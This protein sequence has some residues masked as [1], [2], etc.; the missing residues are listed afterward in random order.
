MKP[1]QDY[2]FLCS[3]Q[4]SDHANRARSGIAVE[5]SHPWSWWNRLNSPRRVLYIFAY[6]SHFWG[7]KMRLKQ[8]GATYVRD[9]N[10]LQTNGK[11]SLGTGSNIWV[12]LIGEC[13]LY[14]K[15]YGNLL[16]YGIHFGSG[17]WLI[18]ISLPIMNLYWWFQPI[19]EYYWWMS[20]HYN[21]H[22]SGEICM[23]VFE[24]AKRRT[25]SDTYPWTISNKNTSI[26]RHHIIL[27]VMLSLISTRPYNQPLFILT[28][29]CGHESWFWSFVAA[30]IASLSSV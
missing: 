28:T 1:S 29:K 10:M 18:L 13:D 30:P 6:E 14:A 12:R 7:L 26:H 20:H 23:F 15:I 27:N 21:W 17:D 11:Q 9:R 16:K 2:E 25:K 4:L 19:T 24:T 3:S 8:G 5:M 22:H